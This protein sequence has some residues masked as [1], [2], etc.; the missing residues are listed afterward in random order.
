MTPGDESSLV[1]YWAHNV[2]VASPTVQAAVHAI[3]SQDVGL[4][5]PTDLSWH[6]WD[7]RVPEDGAPFP[8][9]VVSTQETLDTSRVGGDQ[10]PFMTAVPLV[11]KVIH[12]GQSTLGLGPLLRAI[13]QALQGNT[14]TAVSIPDDPEAEPMTV[15]TSTRVG[16]LRYPEATDGVQY[17][18][19]GATY[20]VRVQ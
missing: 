17:L 5:T 20:T 15:L 16:T 6:V 8:A 12:R 4:D 1:S 9:I 10:D 18:H 11:V 13:H 19:V 3:A 7:D 2:I 14:N